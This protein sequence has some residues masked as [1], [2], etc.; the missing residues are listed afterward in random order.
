VRTLDN[1]SPYYVSFS[2]ESLDDIVRLATSLET[3]EWHR[4]RIFSKEVLPPHITEQILNYVP[5]ARELGL[6][7]TRAAIFISQ[8]GF[9]YRAHK[10]GLRCGFG[11]NYPLVVK[12]ALCKTN[13]YSDDVADSYPLD[14]CD[15]RSRELSGFDKSLHTPVYTATLQPNTGVLFNTDIYHDWDNSASGN[16]RVIM[17]LRSSLDISYDSAKSILGI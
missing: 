1:C 4:N 14:L 3:R 15:G 7:T 12:D 13:W 11:I 8:P 5:Y 9:Y 16:V 17:S 2:H 10:D 6:T